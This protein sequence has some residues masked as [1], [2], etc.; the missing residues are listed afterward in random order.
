MNIPRALQTLEFFFFFFV[1]LNSDAQI[2]LSR[3]AED[4]GVR[5]ACLGEVNHSKCIILTG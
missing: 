5:S 1:V 4:H 3:S 2:S